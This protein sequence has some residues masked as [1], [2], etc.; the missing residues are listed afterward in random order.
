[1]A[2]SLAG[3]GSA[4][5]TAQLR[6]NAPLAEILA[7]GHDGFIPDLS[8]KERDLIMAWIDTNGLFHGSWDYTNH[9][10]QIKGWGGTVIARDDK[11]NPDQ[12][13]LAEK[14]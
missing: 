8:R 7:S 10:C 5:I 9:G 6:L 4:N 12:G 2:Q 13:C 1:M 14:W 11:M 3:S